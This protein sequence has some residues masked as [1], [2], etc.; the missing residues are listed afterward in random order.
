[1]SAAACFPPQTFA[2]LYDKYLARPLSLDDVAALT[3]AITDVYH[4]EGYFLSRAIAPAQDVSNGVLRIEIIEGYIF[5]VAINGDAPSAIKR[6]IYRLKQDLPSRLATV[7]RV[8][9]LIN[10]LPGVSIASSTFEPDPD[11]LAPHRLVIDVKTDRFK[12]N[13]YADNRGTEDAGPVQA[14]ISGSV[15]SV[16]RT[17]DQFSI[18]IFTIPSAPGEL[19]LGDLSYQIPLSASGTYVTL[20]GAVS[21]FD[22]GATLAAFDTESKTKRVAIRLSHPFIRR[23]NI[24]LWGNLSFEAR[25]VTEEQLG[26]M[27]F[28]DKL[29][30]AKASASFRQNHW[31]GVTSIFVE[32]SKG[33]DMLGVESGSAPLS[34]P[35][36]DGQFT[37]FEAFATRYQNIG[38][39]FGFY[40]AIAA[41]ASLDPLLSSQEFAVGGSRFGRAY[42]YAEITGEDGVATLAELRYGRS[43]DLPF[44]DFYQLYGFYDFGAVWNDNANPGFRQQTLMSS[45][46]GLRLTLPSSVYASFEASRP[47][48]R[49][50]FTQDDKDWRGFFSVSKDF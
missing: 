1:M 25:D 34:R 43:V 22:A 26:A 44:L 13:V 15:N 50:P 12:A 20:S 4:R 7:E 29:R 35:D 31:N 16:L 5:D 33:F 17:G 49:I 40:T 9:A 42:D 21:R 10:D 39:V 38:K 46:G 23:R 41:Q 36:A 11:N 18:G 37:K 8:L 3:D 28:E 30:I 45:G 14:Y 48:N 19:I 6:R 2:P 32:A 27:Q 47:L 24:S